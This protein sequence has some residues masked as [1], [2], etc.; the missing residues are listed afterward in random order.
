MMKSLTIAALL[1]ASGPALAESYLLTAKSTCSS[2]GVGLSFSCRNE[3][4]VSGVALS[5]VKDG[6]FWQGRE[7]SRSSRG[8]TTNSFKID[9]IKRDSSVLIFNYPVLYSG[10]AT[11][12]L[13]LKTGRYYF[14]EISYSEAL[15]TKNITIEEGIFT[16]KK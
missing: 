2:T 14:S 16:A 10:I 13:S 4:A 5:L 9:L 6:P 11:I 12:V 3:A 8:V 1:L 15:G 7:Q